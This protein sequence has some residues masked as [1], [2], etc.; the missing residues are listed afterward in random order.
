MSRCVAFR[1]PG[2]LRSPLSQQTCVATMTGL[3]SLAAAK[4]RFCV[5]VVS[6]AFPFLVFKTQSRWGGASSRTFFVCS[7][8]RD[9]CESTMDFLLLLDVDANVWY[10]EFSFCRSRSQDDLTVFLVDLLVSSCLALINPRDQA[11]HD[12]GAALDLFVSGVSQSIA[13]PR[14]DWML[15]ASSRLL[16]RHGSDH[17]LCVVSAQLNCRTTHVVVN[18]SSSQRR[19]LPM[20]QRC[21]LPT[22]WRCS[23]CCRKS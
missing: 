8:L 15:R 4:Q 5:A 16:L 23:T 19:S 9:I 10:P 2:L 20:E 17:R 11:T 7:L 6:H 21:L 14:W 3:L 12:A 1:N 18:S 22:G 13:H